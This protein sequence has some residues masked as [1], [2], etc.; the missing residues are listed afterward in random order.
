MTKIHST[1]VIEKGAEISSDVE[2]GAYSVISSSVIIDSGTKILNHVTISGRTTIG[3][4]NIV[5]PFST[6]GGPPQDITYRNEPTELIIGNENIIRENSTLNIGTVRGNSITSIGNKNLIMAYSHIA[7]D[8]KLEDNILMANGTQLGGHVLIENNATLGG[9]SLIH[10]FV[11]IGRGSFTSMGSAV[12]KDLPPY[13]LASGNYARAIG[14]NK[15][16]LRRSGMPSEVINA[17][18]K[19]FRM[20]VQSR[21]EP[22]EFG[23]KQLT[24]QFI[25]LDHFVKFI[26]NSK[27]GIIRTH[28]KA[29]V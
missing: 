14:L 27:R 26:R 18:S 10:Q 6:L 25:E 1:A 21:H 17:L 11:T 28:L 16:G 23:L 22:D 7:H 29:R 20:L 8:C 15:V 24:T 2:I 3:K 12:N 19:A 9:F 4:K 5:H 13:C